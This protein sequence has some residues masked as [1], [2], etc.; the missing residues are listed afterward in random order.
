MDVFGYILIRYAERY[1]LRIDVP[2]HVVLCVRY[3]YIRTCIHTCNL[4]IF[5]FYR[6]DYWLDE[7]NPRSAYTAS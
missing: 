6:R 5:V 1:W 3:D 2:L 4:G 7:T